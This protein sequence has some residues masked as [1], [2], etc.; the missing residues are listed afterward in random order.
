M[1]T[2]RLGDCLVAMK[3]IQDKSIDMIYLDP[4]FF[5]QK[6]H[7]LTSRDRSQEYSF[8]DI[9][10]C[11]REYAES[12]HRRLAEARRIL[13][14]TGTIFIHCDRS[15]NH[16]LRLV[17]EEVF[18]EENF[19]SEIIWSYKRWSNSANNL[20]P[21]HQNIL[22]FAKTEKYKFKK[23]YTPYS[24]TTNIDQILQK[25]ARD[26]SNK[27]V[28]ARTEDGETI[29]SEEKKGVPLGDVW[30]IPFLNPK[31]K[32]RTGYPTQKPIILLERII[33]ISTDP[34]DV[35]L[36]PFCGSGTTLVASK[37]M[38]RHFIGIDISA[39]A[40]QLSNERLQDLVKTESAVLKHGR[41]SYINADEKSLS[42][43]AGL[44]YIPVQRNAGID[45]ILKSNFQGKPIPIRVQ[46]EGEALSEAFSKLA[47]AAQKKGSKLAFLV[48]TSVDRD[49]IPHAFPDG[50][51]RVIN[52]TALEI[53]NTISSL[54]NEPGLLDA[55]FMKTGSSR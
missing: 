33:E 14:D 52:S 25:R 10:A 37:M 11:H 44:D 29:S 50:I 42:I 23:I 47:A 55:G 48:A 39:E 1:D 38:G 24:E 46:K 49:L 17:A 40:V 3:S 18:G 30:E 7:K 35:V 4:P 20:T 8:N 51:V 53:K 36:D 34:G 27:S 6:K 15:A 16:I 2:V 22:L 32:E 19:V 21:N 12:M 54:S 45:A 26:D 28:Y 5:T 43:I 31:A 9:W 41:T 13:K